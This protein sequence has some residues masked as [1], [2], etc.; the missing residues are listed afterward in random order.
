M[1][2]VVL[3]GALAAS[4]LARATPFNDSVKVCEDNPRYDLRP[5]LKIACRVRVDE[6]RSRG[7]TT[8]LSKGLIT[9][10]GSFTLRVDQ[11]Q[12]GGRFSFFI[13]LGDGPGPRATYADPV[14]PG[15]TYDLVAGWDGKEI[16]LTV[17]GST[18]RSPRTGR[19][20]GNF[21]PLTVGPLKV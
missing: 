10:P 20:Q 17:N 16:Y 19:P 18:H 8:L 1:R 21:T 3:I 14:K 12:E 4:L 15:K 9:E 7:Y 6:I 11:P 2:L 13:N 5:G